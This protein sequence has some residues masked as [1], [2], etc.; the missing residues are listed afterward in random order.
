MTT[1]SLQPQNATSRIRIVGTYFVFLYPCHRQSP[2]SI[3][4]AVLPSDHQNGSSGEQVCN[5]I[6]Y[7]SFFLGFDIEESNL[8][9]A[10]IAVAG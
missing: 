1:H 4:T 10:P 8:P 2:Q 6:P 5:T 3:L 9:V 7:I